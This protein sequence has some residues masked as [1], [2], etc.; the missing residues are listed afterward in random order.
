MSPRSSGMIR[1]CSPESRRQRLRFRLQ[2]VRERYGSF[3]AAPKT[4]GCEIDD[5]V[6]PRQSKILPNV[7]LG[8]LSFRVRFDYGTHTIVSRRFC[9][10]LSFRHAWRGRD[11]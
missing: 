7:V 2:A 10:Q 6:T 1:A 11:A 4:S 5:L 3:I 8:F 9:A